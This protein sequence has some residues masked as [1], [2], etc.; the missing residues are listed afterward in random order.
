MIASVIV[1]VIF[2]GVVGY[3]MAT[4]PADYTPVKEPRRSEL[5]AKLKMHQKMKKAKR[6]K[7]WSK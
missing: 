6:I 5:M 4:D 2:L 3:L 1:F 7:K